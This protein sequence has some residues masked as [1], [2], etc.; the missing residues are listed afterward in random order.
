[1]NSVEGPFDHAVIVETELQFSLVELSRVCGVETALLESLVEEG[2]L[3]PRGDG[4]TEWSFA[5]AIMPRARTATRLLRDLELSAP[6]AAL[7]IDLVDEI[8]RLK[9]QLRR[10]VCG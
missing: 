8:E 9:A 2:V 10:A 5:G 6:G 3:T 1:M 4:P 7:V